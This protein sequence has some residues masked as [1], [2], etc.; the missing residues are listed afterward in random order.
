MVIR[1]SDFRY[2]LFISLL[3]FGMTGCVRA[4]KKMLTAT[5]FAEWFISPVATFPA[6]TR[7]PD[8]P[9]VDSLVSCF[10]QSAQPGTGSV[11]LP[12]TFGQP[13]TIGIETPHVIKKDTEYPCVIYLHGGIGTERNDK[14]I[15]AYRMLSMLNDSSAVFIASP[16]ANRTTPW[17]SPAGLSRI[18]QTVRYMSI[19]FPVNPDK[20]FVAGVSDGATGCWA[21]ANSI[22]GPFAGFFPVSGF[23]GM[24]SRFGIQLHPQN[25]MQRPIYTVHAGKDRLYPAEI[26]NQFLDQLEAAG[27]GVMRKMYPDE[28][29]GFDYRFRECATLCSL[30]TA[31]E[32]PS[33]NGFI[34]N[35]DTRLPLCIDRFFSVV[36][37]ERTDRKVLLR[38]YHN[39]DTLYIATRGIASCGM[40]FK[41]TNTGTMPMDVSVNNVSR[42]MRTS[43]VT[44]EQLLRMM[45]YRCCSL[46]TDYNYLEFSL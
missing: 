42:R 45:K 29:H 23:G 44:G 1:K 17:W 5:A 35:C 31:W 4:G 33:A 40:Y 43:A 21:V 41:K 11:V 2:I 36:Y 3:L 16:S 15:S 28:E 26:V 32:R 14:G 38:S 10:R 34:W 6:D 37:S 22:A 9:T 24:L 20:I 30:I 39:N 27:V 18:L 25:L 46:C 12:D 13:F 19:H 8:Q 7:L